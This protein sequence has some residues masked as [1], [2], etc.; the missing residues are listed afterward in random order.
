MVFGEPPIHP[1]ELAALLIERVRRDC[2]N[3]MSNTAWTRAIKTAL[4]ERGQV[5]GLLV[6]PD[7]V[8][9]QGEYLLD[10]I[11]Q[12]QP[13]CRDILLAVESEWGS[14]G[15]VLDDFE[16]LLH[17]KSPLKL[18]VSWLQGRYSAQFLEQLRTGYLMPFQ[19]HIRGE[20][21]VW[22]NFVG[23][24]GNADCYEFVAA[25]D[26]KIQTASLAPLAFAKAGVP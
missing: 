13:P 20:T 17:V 6:S 19:Q 14:C 9:G 12:L 25:Q 18:M 24:A 5:L 21:Y 10:M 26:G 15:D 7:P 11:W 8:S 16:K 23:M 4:A 1:A 3:N 2:A 22:V